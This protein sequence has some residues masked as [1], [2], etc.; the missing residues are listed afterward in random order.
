MDLD[1]RRRR[2]EGVMGVPREHHQQRRAPS[3]NQW[4]EIYAQVRTPASPNL[5]ENTGFSPLPSDSDCGCDGELDLCETEP[6]VEAGEGGA[7]DSVVSQV[8]C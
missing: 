6:T 1:S 5:V 7:R 2:K 8:Q 4:S 3:R